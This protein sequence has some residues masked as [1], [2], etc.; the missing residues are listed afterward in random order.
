MSA[1][2]PFKFPAS[3]K[4]DAIL[5]S[6]VTT[7]TT[8]QVQAAKALFYV[9]MHKV[10]WFKKLHFLDKFWLARRQFPALRI[11]YDFDQTNRPSRYSTA[12]PH[13]NTCQHDFHLNLP[14]QGNTTPFWIPSWL[15]P[16]QCTFEPRKHFFTS[17]CISSIGFKNATFLTNCDLLADSFPRFVF[18]TILIGWLDCLC[19]LWL[20]SHFATTYGTHLPPRLF[21]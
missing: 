9:I 16:P 10:L 8:M 2:L 4:Y 19:P 21:T 18:A 17:L 5:D 14:L 1:L 20:A 11:C 12:Q 3:G 7:T 6:F 13:Q 15:Q